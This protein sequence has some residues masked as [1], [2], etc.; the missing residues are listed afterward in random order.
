MCT[1]FT[2]G[3]LL[4]SLDQVVIDKCDA[5]AVSPTQYIKYVLAEYEKNVNRSWQTLAD[6]YHKELC[7]AG[8]NFPE[9]YK[10]LFFPDYLASMALQLP[11]TIGMMALL[12][13]SG[14]HDQ[15]QSQTLSQNQNAQQAV[16]STPATP[17]SHNHGNQ[18]Q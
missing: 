8:S 16:S 6:C 10:E 17:Q 5:V 15:S 1:V 13:T 2:G 7:F 18:R 12:V 9:L 14:T 11:S 4:L 3:L